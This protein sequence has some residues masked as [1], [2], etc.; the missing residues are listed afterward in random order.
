MLEAGGI[1]CRVSGYCFIYYFEPYFHY[2]LDDIGL[3]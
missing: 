1:R 2:H 3:S